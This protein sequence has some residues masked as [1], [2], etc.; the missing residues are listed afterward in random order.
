MDRK[1]AREQPRKVIQRP[2]RIVNA[3]CDGIIVLVRTVFGKSLPSRRRTGG[4]L[5]NESR[6]ANN[7]WIIL[8]FILAKIQCWVI[9]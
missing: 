9:K 1:T 5:T 6:I 3:V 7:Q 4:V 8:T 2:K